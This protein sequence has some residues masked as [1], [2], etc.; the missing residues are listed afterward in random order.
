MHKCSPNI[1]V[2]FSGNHMDSGEKNRNNP[3][4]FKVMSMNAF[5]KSRGSD[6]II[7]TRV[8]VYNMHT[9]TWN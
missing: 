5:I 9:W 7:Q 8:H 3:F 4:F 6:K 1:E 2:E